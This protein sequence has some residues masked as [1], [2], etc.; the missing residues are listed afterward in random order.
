LN[1]RAIDWVQPG[2]RLDLPALINTLLQAD[3]D[4]LAYSHNER[5][6]DINDEAALANAEQLWKDSQWPGEP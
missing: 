1:R 5:W 3:D 2:V 6:I 4:V